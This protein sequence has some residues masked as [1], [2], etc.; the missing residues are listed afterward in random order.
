MLSVFFFRNFP[1]L[2]RFWDDPGPPKIDTKSKKSCSGRFWNA[3]FI[4]FGTV[5]GGFWKGLGRVLGG[6]RQ[7]FRDF[8]VLGE[9]CVKFLGL[10]D[11]R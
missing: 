3:L 10:Q 1:I 2:A 4:V 9:T 8:F 6:F 5:W 11:L 7:D